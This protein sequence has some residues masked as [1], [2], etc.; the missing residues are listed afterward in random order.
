MIAPDT[1]AQA[2]TRVRITRLAHG[3]DLPLPSYQSALAAGLDLIA[4]VAADDPIVIAPG[5]RALVPTGIAIAMPEGFEAQVR[6]RSGLAM[7]HGLT[8]LNSPGTIDA[9]YRGEIQ[10][11]LV[12]LGG[13]S[14][15]LTRGMRIAQLV[16]AT[17]ARARLIEVDSLD[18]TE[19]GSG[20]FGSTGG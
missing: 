5:A 4:A 19:R 16:V 3:H 20:G 1:S 6:P 10:V 12:N 13:E 14:V 9:D 18:Q 8:V 7:R 15:Q 11:L 2:E 17:V